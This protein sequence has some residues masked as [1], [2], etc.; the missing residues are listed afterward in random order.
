MKIKHLQELLIK[1]QTL[2][3]KDDF[4]EAEYKKAKY[5]KLQMTTLNQ[6]KMQKNI[7]E[8]K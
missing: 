4:Y 6:F 3:D 8:E 1:L 2:T 7:E 5:E